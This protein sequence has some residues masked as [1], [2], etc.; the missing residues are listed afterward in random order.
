[1]SSGPSGPAGSKSHSHSGAV[2]IGMALFFGFFWLICF[3]A[4]IQTTEAG[5]AHGGLVNTFQPDWSILLQP[6][7]FITGNMPASEGMAFIVAWPVEL[8][9][10]SFIVLG[11]ELMLHA[12]SR[13]G[14]LAGKIFIILALAATFYNGWNDYHYGTLGVGNGGHWAFVI[15]MAGVVGFFGTLCLFCF[16]KG[17]KHA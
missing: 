1:M 12:A 4:Q 15:V 8:M 6:I 17:W 13:S 14:Q 10:L 11:I 9:Y 16:E 3:M 2:F 7:T 5:V